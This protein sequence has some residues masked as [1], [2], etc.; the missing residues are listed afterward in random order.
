MI[1][2]SM[3]LAR[4]HAGEVEGGMEMVQVAF[5]L[6]FAVTLG[7]LVAAVVNGTVK[8]GIVEVNT[9]SADMFSELLTTTSGASDIVNPK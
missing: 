3:L 1:N 7:A 9:A 6:L 8:A 4:L 5:S 2:K